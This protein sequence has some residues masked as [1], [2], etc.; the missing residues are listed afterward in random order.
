M[1]II[2]AMKRL[3][4]IEKRMTDNNTAITAY[5]SILST[6]RPAFD[7][8]QEQRKQVQSLIQ[9]NEDLLKEYLSLK[10]KIE[11]TNLAVVVEMDGKK[12]TLS[13]LLI[14]K[15]KLA[16]TAMGTYEALNDRTATAKLRSASVGPDGKAP[17]VLRLY[18]ER[19]KNA[20]LDKWQD[21]YNNCDSRLEVINCTTDL[22]E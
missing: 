12:Y 5:A 10:T 1:K 16:K 21:L 15:R 6:E 14:L 7:S 2:E 4:V 20:A 3:K 22:V 17:Q 9:A 18:D 13:E 11:R 19:V 8:E